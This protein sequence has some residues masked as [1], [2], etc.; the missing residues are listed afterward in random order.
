MDDKRR[1][2]PLRWALFIVAGAVAFAIALSALFWIVGLIFHLVPTILR[3]AVILG[4]AG[5][6]WW[7][8]TGRR[9]PSRLP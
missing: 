3:L 5:A 8:V 9:R 6:V 2:G 1:Y 7:L 4:V